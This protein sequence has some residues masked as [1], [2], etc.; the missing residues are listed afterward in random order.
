MEI[1]LPAPASAPAV[2][3]AATAE[4]GPSGQPGATAAVGPAAAPSISGP[5][6]GSW[7]YPSRYLHR[8]VTTLR[9]I[10]PIY[11]EAAATISGRV[12]IL[13]LV[14]EYGQVDQHRIVNADPSG[15]FEASVIEAFAQKARYA[16]GLIAGYPVKAQLIAEVTFEPGAPPQTSFS[17]MDPQQAP[18]TGLPAASVAAPAPA[19]APPPSLQR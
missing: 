19:A 10:L 11:P 13:L 12:T 7:Y 6:A 3:A 14:N 15:V 2:T 17:I 8:R 16:P 1:P 5:F 4:P 9:P 18:V